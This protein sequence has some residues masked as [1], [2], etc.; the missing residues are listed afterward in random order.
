MPVI[1]SYRSQTLP[2]L[3]RT[4]AM[5]APATARIDPQATGAR[6]AILAGRFR[7]MRQDGQAAAGLLAQAGQVRAQGLSRLAGVAR[8]ASETFYHVGQA[9]TLSQSRLGFQRD[10]LTYVQELKD[11]GDHDKAPELI[12]QKTQELLGKYGQGLAGS[13]RLNYQ[14]AAQTAAL[15]AEIGVTDWARKKTV[16]AALAG[17]QEES[18]LLK[19]RF[20]AARSAGEK[21]SILA[22]HGRLLDQL[23]E[24]GVLSRTKAVEQKQAFRRDLAFTEVQGL[25]EQDPGAALRL[26]RDP[27]SFPD[28]EPGKRLVLTKHAK[29]AVKSLEAERRDSLEMAALEDLQA[30]F[31]DDFPAMLNAVNSPAWLKKRGLNLE[32]APR[33]RAA[34]NSRRQAERLARLEAQEKRN[35]ELTGQVA[36]LADQGKLPQARRLL[37]R[38]FNLTARDS[39]QG[40]GA[41][42]LSSLD[43]WLDRRESK[44]LQARGQAA[45]AFVT[46]QITSG[47]R[48]DWDTES[49][50]A[51]G[52]APGDIPGFLKMQAKQ[53]EHAQGARQKGLPNQLSRFKTMVR[54]QFKSGQT[55]EEGF[56]KIWPR[57]ERRFLDR[58]AAEELDLYDPRASK[59]AETLAQEVEIDVPNQ[60]SDY[61]G[62][63]GGAEVE[64]EDLPGVAPQEVFAVHY[65]LVRAGMEDSVDNKRAV[66]MAI[67]ALRGQGK[68]T[69]TRS[70]ERMLEHH[71]RELD[72]LAALRW[73]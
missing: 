35:R 55:G 36:A 1:Q 16:D 65:Y 64:D 17:Y 70:I 46:E 40:Y 26:L 73:R 27:K 72:R 67:A 45:A 15:R 14:N 68:P 49:L 69:S 57:C 66:A 33:L 32:S 38:A 53:K 52:V 23:V 6:D 10:L 28:L 21:N 19:Q 54:S 43:A 62:P 20:A 25:I 22:S 13:Y 31:G 71:G 12:R 11:K 60:W 2:P 30:R 44:A 59:I 5:P 3:S 7:E 34:V 4:P 50:A 39:G 37:N 61:E 24:A 56:W 47:R 42:V 8:Q 58:L 41:A 48:L 9:A 29:A 63:L 18:L 51:A